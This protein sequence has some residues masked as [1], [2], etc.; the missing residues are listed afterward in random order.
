[1]KENEVAKTCIACGMPMEKE[2]DHARGDLTK[3]YCVHCAREDGS[4]QSY[5][6]K[7]ASFTR[8]LVRTKGLDEREG[9]AQARRRMRGLAA[10]KGRR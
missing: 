8:F 2:A 4:M 6:E 10:W 3:D 9:G 5:E 1:M 7:L